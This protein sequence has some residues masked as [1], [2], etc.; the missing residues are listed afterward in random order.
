VIHGVQHVF[1]PIQGLDRWLDEGHRTR[2][3]FI[4]HGIPKDGIKTLFGIMVEAAEEVVA[5]ERGKLKE[6]E[7]QSGNQAPSG[8]EP[9]Q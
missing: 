7:S 8:S 6:E 9:L 3:V 1:Y 4:T 5:A 2:L